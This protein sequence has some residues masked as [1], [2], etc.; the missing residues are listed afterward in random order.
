[1]VFIRNNSSEDA[2]INTWWDYG[3]WYTAVAK[4]RVLFDGKTQNSPVAFWMAKVFKTSDEDEA[5]GIL[6]MLDISK[7][8]AFDLL[9]SYGLSH[10]QIINTLSDILKLPELDARVYLKKTLDD[11]KI[12]ALIPLLYKN[13]IPPAYFIASFDTM[14]KIRAISHIANWDFKKG[15][16]WL[17]F[18]RSNPIG[19]SDYLGKEYGY[20]KEE[21]SGLYRDLSLLNDR[22]ALPWISHIDNIYPNSLSNKSKSTDSLIVFDNA[23]TLDLTTYN[24]YISRGP[25]VDIGIPYSVAYVK[26]GVLEENTQEGSNLDH[27]VLVFKEGEDSYKN[28]FLDKDLVRSMF[29]RMYFLK[30]ETLKYF[31]KVHEEKT[32]DGNYVFVYKIEWS[33]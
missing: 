21:I 24:A 14:V 5:I 4:R 28:I 20:N 6:R 27:S 13:D 18:A 8:K 15:D 16:I 25:D 19:F 11:K 26:D 33:K 12:D 17:H 29:S 9:E 3:H 32:P 31:K 30:G 10:T 22:E 7:N 23:M 2:I 1:L